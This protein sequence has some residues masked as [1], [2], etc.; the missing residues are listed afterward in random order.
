VRKEEPV[1]EVDAEREG[2]R[3]GGRSYCHASKLQKADLPP[4][5]FNNCYRY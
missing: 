2:G 1:D 3:E 5:S 4:V